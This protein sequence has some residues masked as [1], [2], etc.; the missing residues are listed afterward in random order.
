[1]SLLRE[2]QGER[3]AT[4]EFLA[5]FP[6]HAAT[7]AQQIDLHRALAPGTFEGTIPSL[8]EGATLGRG[9]GESGLPCVPGYEVLGVLGRG[10]MGVVYQARQTGLDRTVALKMLLAGGCAGEEELDRFRREAVAVARLQHPNVVQIHEV[11]EHDGLPFFSL[12]FCPGGSLAHRLDGTPWPTPRAAALVE[13]LARAL[14]AAHERG[15]IHRDLKPA[16]VLL[17]DGGEPKVADF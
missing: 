4:Q 15:I 5:R 11:G 14:Q 2:Q 16:N 10:G 3:P 9:T 17:T 6:E 12:E 8:G 13:T 7:L 1:E